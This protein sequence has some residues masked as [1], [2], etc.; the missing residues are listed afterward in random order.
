MHTVGIEF[1]SR[2]VSIGKQSL[3]LQIWDTA[4]QE[5]FRS[6]TRNYYRGSSGALLVYDISCRSS[7]DK[8]SYWMNELKHHQAHYK[9][10]NNT[11]NSSN[12]VQSSASLIDECYS[13]VLVGNKSDLQAEREVSLSEGKALASQYSVDFMETSALTSE[14]VEAAFLKLSRK[15]LVQI[16]LGE[17]NITFYE[18]F[19]FR[20]T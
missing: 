3:R 2:T 12:K 4:G 11:T 5:R 10:N 17:I 6:L 18:T 1:G 14:N 9:N 15:I 19:C 20:Q 8:V 16:E 13:V 7:F